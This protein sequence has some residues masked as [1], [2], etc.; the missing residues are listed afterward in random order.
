MKELFAVLTV[1]NYA[2][3]DKYFERLS[4]LCEIYIGWRQSWRPIHT[5]LLVSQRVR[6]DEI[7]ILVRM[8][9]ARDLTKR[10][11]YFIGNIRMCLASH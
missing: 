9:I 2:Y 8:Y 5:L 7:V 3:T 10:R 11:Y 4:Q 6:Y 1:I